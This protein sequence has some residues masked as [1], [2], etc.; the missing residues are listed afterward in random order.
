MSSVR[1]LHLPVWGPY[2]LVAALAM[3]AL[4]PLFSRLPKVAVVACFDPSHLLY[5]LV[6][7]SEPAGAVH[8]V[9]APARVVSWTLLVAATLVV[10][11]VLVPA[12]LLAATLILR[13]RAA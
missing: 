5:S 6:P 9:S 2:L 8:C 3:A 13:E 1:Q 12:A 7:S 4:L 11:L 10:Q